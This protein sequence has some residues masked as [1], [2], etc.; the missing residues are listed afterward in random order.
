MRLM[1]PLPIQVLV[2]CKAWPVAKLELDGE[3]EAN[4]GCCIY[5]YMPS[6]SITSIVELSM[7]EL[8]GHVCSLTRGCVGVNCDAWLSWQ[9][10]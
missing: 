10:W 2:V 5:M 7:N 4:P 3:Y 6:Q 8:L 1:S 9:P